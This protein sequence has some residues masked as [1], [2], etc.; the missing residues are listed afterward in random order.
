MLALDRATRQEKQLPVQ[1]EQPP[2]APGKRHGSHSRGVGRRGAAGLAR[3]VW[4]VRGVRPRRVVLPVA[5]LAVLLVAVVWGG[6][7]VMSPA[8]ASG[9]SALFGSING[10]GQSKQAAGIMA[11]YNTMQA[12]MSASQ[13]LTTDA[14]PVHTDADQVMAQDN[15]SSSSNTA[16]QTGTS[17]T[18]LAPP[19]SPS[20][21][22]KIAQQ[23]MPG[24]GFSV[25]SQWS[26]LY[27]IWEKESTWNVYAANPSS[28][29]YG[30]PQANPGSMMASV[31]SDWRTNPT[32]QI[33]W[34]LG[35]IQSR[36]GTP[37]G[38]WDHEESIG[39]Y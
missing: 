16:N 9:A 29:A 35:Y 2:A 37:C 24:F 23:L 31:A 5:G 25:A 20:A 30:I 34:G 8:Q 38:A 27:S 39:W 6:V 13:V 17:I 32:T 19:N 15:P 22:Q 28:E 14:M 11:E 7:Q 10:L 26:C 18:T 36:Y 3:V 4:G 33:K 12:M 21:D 1:A